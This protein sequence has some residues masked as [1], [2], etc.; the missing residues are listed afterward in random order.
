[1]GAD[2]IIRVLF[3]ERYAASVPVF[4]VS[5]LTVLLG[6]LQVDGVLRVYAQTRLLFA[7][8]VLRLALVLGL[9]LTTSPVTT[10]LRD[11]VASVV[12]S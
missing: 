11:S 5:S 6:T 12:L 1:M 9:M 10:P 2:A 3:T 8:N 7:L 4:M